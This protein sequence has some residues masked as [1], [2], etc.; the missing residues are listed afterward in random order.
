LGNKKEENK[1][2]KFF[3][4]ILGSAF[5]FGLA[6]T[7]SASEKSTAEHCAGHKDAAQVCEEEVSGHNHHDHHRHH[8]GSAAAP[9]E[10]K[11][12]EMTEH[13][14]PMT[15]AIS[16]SMKLIS[17]RISENMSPDAMKKWAAALDS[18]SSLSLRLSDF[19]NN[20]SAD[21]AELHMLHQ[22]IDDLSKSLK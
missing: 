9:K 15:K 18:V 20:G 6:V 12:N 7:G 2:S 21:E 19:M 14:V 17:R 16:D 11:G 8:H 3:G 1:M 4:L 5:I 10:L 13:L 22:E